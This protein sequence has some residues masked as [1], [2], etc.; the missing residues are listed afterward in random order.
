M[1]KRCSR[2]LHRFFFVSKKQEI[3][4]AERH[5]AEFGADGG[6][7]AGRGLKSF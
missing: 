3:K 7:N 4:L 6:G 2:R 5:V 1:N